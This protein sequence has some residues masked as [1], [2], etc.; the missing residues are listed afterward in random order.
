MIH[1]QCATG[2]FGAASM[3]PRA[4]SLN[5]D[6]AKLRHREPQRGVA[7]HA[8]RLTLS[9][10]VIAV[11]HHG[12]PRRHARRNDSTEAGSAMARAWVLGVGFFHAIALPPVRYRR[13]CMREMW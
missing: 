3:G 6:I 5:K 1:Q 12:L 10:M 2:T 9:P 8:P 4:A 13:V 11:H 7:I